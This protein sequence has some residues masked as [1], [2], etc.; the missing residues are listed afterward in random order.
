[1]AAHFQ[2]E[3]GKKSITCAEAWIKRCA[4]AGLTVKGDRMTMIPGF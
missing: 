2:K 3:L 4:M 1:V